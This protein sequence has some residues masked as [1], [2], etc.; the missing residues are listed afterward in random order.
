MIAQGV[1]SLIELG[2]GSVLAG[3]VKRVDK[4]VSA[5]SLGAPADFEKFLSAG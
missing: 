4:Q 5:V 2:C 1:S 3:L